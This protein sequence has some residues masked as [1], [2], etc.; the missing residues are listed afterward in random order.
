MI[1]YRPF[2]NSD[3]PGLSAV[4]RSQELL[5]GRFHAMTPALLEQH[6]FS[7]LYF[8]HAGLIV[9]EEGG[10]IVGFVHAGFGCDEA[11]AAL[12]HEVGSICQ[13]QVSDHPERQSIGKQL[14]RLAEEYLQGR[15]AGVIYGGGARPLNPFY[16]GLY[17]GSE[18]PGVLESDRWFGDLLQVSGYK[19]CQR[20]L[21][22]ERDLG[23][24]RPPVD[25]RQMQIRRG[26]TIE[27]TFDPPT[28]NWW[29]SC[30]LGQT[31][32]TRFDLRGRNAERPHATA[33]FWD[34]EPLASSW[35]VHAVGLIRV[36][37]DSTQ[38]RQGLASYLIAEALRQLRAHGVARCEVQA[39][40]ENEAA[41]GL[42]RKL[43]FQQIDQGAVYRK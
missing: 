8:D 37:V 22:F 26:N 43:G 41:V 19:V 34:L 21:V 36:E 32:R 25:R 31:D 3:P 5:R 42:Y 17:G 6:V 9:A 29:Q 38:R 12:N 4:W 10:W 24:F 11:E 14:V 35:G 16:L 1:N 40:Q 18:A 30:T 2:R 28:E 39:M 33:T 27:A 20:S 7:K 23:G 15:G 13:L